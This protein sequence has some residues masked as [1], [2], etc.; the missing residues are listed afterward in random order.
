[1]VFV[2]TAVTVLQLSVYSAAIVAGS[3]AVGISAGFDTQASPTGPPGNVP[4]NTG[5]VLSIIVIICV[6]TV[7]VL[8]QSSVTVQVLVI[9]LLQ[10]APCTGLPAVLTG[11]SVLSHTSVAIGSNACAVASAAASEHCT[12]LSSE[13]AAVVQVGACVSSMVIVCVAVAVFPQP[14]VMV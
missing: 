9:V 6:N 13:P 1:M 4:V 10:F 14:S 3:G 5:A 7:L 11:V 2:K 8:P 12:V